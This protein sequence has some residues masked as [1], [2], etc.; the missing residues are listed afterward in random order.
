V[1]GHKNKRQNYSFFTCQFSLLTAAYFAKDF[2]QDEW[3]GLAALNR[4]L[5][6]FPNSVYSLI[7]P[8]ETSLPKTT[9]DAFRRSHQETPGRVL[10]Q[11][12][13]R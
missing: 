4:P 8:M 12:R 5:R 6:I 7:N 10:T 1:V 3:T 11:R 9:P 13:C 2:A